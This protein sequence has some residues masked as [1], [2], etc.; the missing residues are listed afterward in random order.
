MA[1]HIASKLALPPADPDRRQ[2]PTRVLVREVLSL[3]AAERAPELAVDQ[4]SIDGWIAHL[5]A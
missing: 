5:C 3:Y 4:A 2:D 1:S